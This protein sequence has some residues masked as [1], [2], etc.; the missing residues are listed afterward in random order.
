VFLAAVGNNNDQI[1]IGD[2]DFWRARFGKTFGV[3]AGAAF[4]AP[5][6]AVP[7]PGAVALWAFGVAGLRLFRWGRGK[8]GA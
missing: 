8:N 6:A 5:N 1:D 4:D 7:E 2:D 3:G